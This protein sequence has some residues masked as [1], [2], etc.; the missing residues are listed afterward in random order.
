M[1]IKKPT[2]EDLEKAKNKTVPDL[3]KPNLKVLFV[4]INP[5]LYTTAIGHHFGRPGNRFWPALFASGFTPRLFSPYESEKL[6]DLN[7]GITNMVKRTTLRA[8]ELTKEELLQGRI[9]LEKL[10]L[11]NKPKYICILGI[12]SYRV[13]FEKPKAQMG[14]QDEIIGNTKVWVLTNPSGLNAHATPARL[15]ELFT[16]LREAVEKE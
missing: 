6:L 9:D 11:E 5:G 10:V 12:G 15:K 8:D 13:A 2:K 3:V 7:L 1:E 16:E 14:L 4:G